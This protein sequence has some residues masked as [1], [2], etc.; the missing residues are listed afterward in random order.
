L[1]VINYALIDATYKE[2]NNQCRLTIAKEPLPVFLPA[3]VG[4]SKSGIY[5][6]AINE[7]GVRTFGPKKRYKPEL[8]IW[9]HMLK[10]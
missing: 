3:S 2:S 7:Q 9:A 10:V 8:A 6:K 4:L 1:D 5:T